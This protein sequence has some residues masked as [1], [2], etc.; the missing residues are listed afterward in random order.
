M[1][2]L[3]RRKGESFTVGRCITITLN[4][5][6]AGH[7]KIGV[8]APPCIGVVRDDA[9]ECATRPHEDVFDRILLHVV[10]MSDDERAALLAVMDRERAA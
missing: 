2:L 9:K 6:R 4:D 3:G 5:A 1:L 8:T 7:A 10:R